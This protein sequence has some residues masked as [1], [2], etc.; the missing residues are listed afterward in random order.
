M[1]TSVLLRLRKKSLLRL[2]LAFPFLFLLLSFLT[3][4]D[5]NLGKY[6]WLQHRKEA[7]RKEVAGK[8]NQ[9]LEREKLVLFKVGLGEIRTKLRWLSSHEFEFN[10]GLYDVVEAAVEEETVFLWCWA[11][12]E[13]T[14]LEKEIDLVVSRSLGK[15]ARAALDKQDEFSP[16]SKYW[17]FLLG[18]RLKPT[19]PKSGLFICCQPSADYFY[20]PL[21]PP[22]PPPR[23]S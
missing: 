6:L 23:F 22:E 17:P 14:S 15:K 16:A 19:E 9:G 8:I 12:Q 3:F 4:L 7:V 21:Q 2:Y 11:D 20:F 18:P 1:A 13:E 5:P 10:H